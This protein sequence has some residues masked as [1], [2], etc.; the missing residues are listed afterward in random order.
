MAAFKNIL[1]LRTESGQSV[2]IDLRNA[3]ILAAAPTTSTEAREGMQAYVVSGGTITAEYVCT[4]VSGSTYTW[5]KREV[6]GGGSADLTEVNERIDKLSEAIAELGTVYIG[7][8]KP[9]DGT[10]YW[11]DT[12]DAE[13]EPETVTYTVTKNLTNATIDNAAETVAEKSSYAATLTA[14]EGYA[15]SSVVVTMNGVDITA[16]AYSNGNIYI[17]SVTGDIVITAV[18]VKISTVV[19][20]I[21]NNLLN[22]ANSNPAVSVEENAEYSATLTPATD[23]ELGTVTVTMGGVDITADAYADGVINILAI[24][25]DVVISATGIYAPATPVYELPEPYVGGTAKTLEYNVVDEDKTFSVVIDFSGTASAYAILKA[26]NGNDN[27]GI[28]C[29]GNYFWFAQSQFYDTV[30]IAYNTVENMRVVFTHE[31]G[32]NRLFAH[33]IKGGEKIVTELGTKYVWKT[34]ESCETTIGAGGTINDLKIYV[35]I[36]NESEINDYLGVE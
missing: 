24:T 8:E 27:F 12:S 14:D 11:L 32:S 7:K 4:A 21:T 13:T 5:V 19:Y 17:A 25:G 36:L 31:K 10:L 33:Y 35:R 30:E 18:S 26:G 22:V 9:T 2:S 20:T 23:Y 6:S 1:E 16:T 3:L 15:L 34:G 29:H 28:R